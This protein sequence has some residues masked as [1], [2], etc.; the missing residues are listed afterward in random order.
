MLMFALMNWGQC[1]CL[2]NVTLPRFVGFGSW[3]EE[4]D[5]GMT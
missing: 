4:L 2:G 5:S 1:D 3:G